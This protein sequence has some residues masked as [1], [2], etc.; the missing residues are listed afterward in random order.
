MN[1]RIEYKFIDNFI[2]STKQDRMKY[3]F[4]HPAKRD[5]AIA[6]FAHSW[7]II[8]SEY[9]VED[10]KKMKLENFLS[11]FLKYVDEN[12]QCYIISTYTEFDGKFYPLKEAIEL[13][14]DSY[15]EMIIIIN[16]VLALVFGEYVQGPKPKIILRK[17]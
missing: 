14:L 2:I 4:A 1:E 11:F 10:N 12:H 17:N 16:D 8:I 7:N 13:G 5:K 6:R 9:I 15:M 3:D